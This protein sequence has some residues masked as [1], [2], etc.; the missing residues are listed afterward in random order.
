MRCSS[1]LISVS[2][3]SNLRLKNASAS[4][5]LPACHE[6]ITRSPSAVRTYTVPSASTR[7]QGSLALVTANLLLRPEP[8]VKGE[9]GLSNSDTFDGDLLLGMAIT[10]AVAVV[11]ARLSYILDDSQSADDFAERC[12]ARRKRRRIA[13]YE[14]EL[15]PV[16]ARAGV[17]HGDGA[18]G[19]LCS[20]QI[21]ISELVPRATSASSRGVN[22]LQ[23][24][25]AVRGEPVAGG[26]AEVVLVGQVDER[27][28]GAR[29]L[30]VEQV[31][32]DRAPVG[33]DLGLVLGGLEGW[34]G[35]RNADLA[36]GVAVRCVRA[37]AGGLCG[38]RRRGRCGGRRGG[39]GRRAGARGGG[40]SRGLVAAAG[41]G[42]VAA[43]AQ[44]YHGGAGGHDDADPPPSL[45]S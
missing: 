17:R 15:A 10:V 42:D 19:V 38:Q 11:C 3:A 4:S 40:R 8:Q 39:G 35:R 26:V 45:G 21:L 25:D 22:A 14:E 29:R 6:P 31:E 16:G 23:H 43:R 34:F 5:G 18:L 12:V 27:V 2:S 1:R 30:V 36:G 13:V 7:P 32:D 9:S 44:S 20:R 33:L 41:Q 24:I 37:V 28:D